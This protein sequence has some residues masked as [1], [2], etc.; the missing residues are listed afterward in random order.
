MLVVGAVWVAGLSDDGSGE[1][2]APVGE[3]PEEVEQ[4]SDSPIE[5]TATGSSAT[6]PEVRT[7]TTAP[8]LEGRVAYQSTEGLVILDLASGE[9]HVFADPV[10]P[11][12]ITGGWLL[13]SDGERSLRVD[14]ADPSTLVAVS[15][16]GEVVPT[17]LSRIVAIIFDDSSED[18][19]RNSA[20]LSFDGGVIGTPAQL[21]L[22][23]T[24]LAVPGVGI[25]VVLPDGGSYLVGKEGLERRSVHPIIAAS[26][27]FWIEMRC[28]SDLSCLPFLVDAA[29]GAA[30]VLD[31]PLSGPL[32][33][34]PDGSAVLFTDPS[35]AASSGQACVEVTEQGVRTIGLD[36]AGLPA[37][38][39]DASSFA[40]LSDRGRV[41][42]IV[43][44][45]AEAE[46]ISLNLRSIGLPP[47]A[48]AD[49][50]Y[51]D[52]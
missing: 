4:A 2:A 37:W 14:R 21:P 44:N 9:A 51:Y 32:S 43:D 34:S 31:V 1:A 28:S 18:G 22:G 48:V 26:A 13:V 23:S 7:V 46:V 8:G 20:V 41:L 40:W 36:L 3:S 27:G 25:I 10:R 47:A 39:D 24:E 38:L 11:V 19:R 42:Q 15:T 29:S 12:G 52:G 49:L 35:C 6:G 30:D 16:Y 50:V 45:S 33:V 5:G 17:N